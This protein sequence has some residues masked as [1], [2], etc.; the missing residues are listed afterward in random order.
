MRYEGT[1]M[2]APKKNI[3]VRF[4]DAIRK[5]ISRVAGL[6]GLADADIIRICVENGLPVVEEAFGAMREKFKTLANQPQ[7]KEGRYP[8]LPPHAAEMNEHPRRKKAG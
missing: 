3:S 2:S 7:A 5:E 6:C 4:D 8:V 1:N